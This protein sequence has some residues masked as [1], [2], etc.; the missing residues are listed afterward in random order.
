[1][2]FC[3]NTVTALST[4]EPMLN[5]AEMANGKMIDILRKKLSDVVV[6]TGL[7]NH[8][9]LY[10]LL[11]YNYMKK[12]LFLFAVVLTA[13][14]ILAADVSLKEAKSAA[15][16]F[17][18]KQIKA[19]SLNATAASNLQLVK[20]EASVAKPTA[21]D[22][23]IFNTDHSY[24][25]VSGD[26]QAPEILMYGVEGKLDMD[27][28]PPAMQWL[29]NK[30]KYQI[31]GL[32]AGTMK[33]VS[34]P[35]FS[36]T[37]VAPLVT[38]NWDQ[39]SPYNN[40]CPT[41]G[42]RRAVTGCPAT[43]LA[44]CYYKWKWPETFPALPA[45][46][47]SSS[48]GYSAAALAERAA[49]WDNIIDEYTGPS[50]YSSTTAQKNAVAW[51]MR[52]AGQAIPD[53]M[54]GADASG[55]DDPEIY[56]GVLNMGY[57]DA[58]YLQLTQIY[59]S[60][61]T[62]T[63][64]PQQ[65]TDAQWNQFMLNELYNGRPIEYLA[66][67]ITNGQVSGHA[68]N[69]F[70]CNTSGQYYVNWGWSGDSNG[71]C[72]LHNFTTATGSTGQSGS[73]VF[74]YGEAMI[75]GIEPPAGASN[76]PSLTISPTSLSFTGCT[77]GETYTK[78]FT[79]SGANLTDNV[80]I[81]SDKDAFTVSP[82][83]LTA[84]QAMAGATITVTF[85]PTAAG[86]Q[87]GTITVAS[88]GAT[89]KTVTVSGSATVP[90]PVLTVN[91]TSLSFSGCVVGQ[92]YTQTF[93]VSA[94]N[95]TGSVNISSNNAR[96]TVSPSTLTAAQ[97]MAGATITVTYSPTAAGTH[98]GTISV[99]STGATTKTVS[100]SG[101]AT[102]T[103]TMTVTPSTLNMSTEVG[104]PV[105]AIFHLQGSNLTSTVMLSVSGTGFSINKTNILKSAANN[106]TDVTVTYNPTSAGTHTGT[107][108]LTSNG[109]EPVTVAL[110]GVASMPKFAPVML[111]ADE[112]K[113]TAT[114]FC[115]DWT[116]QTDAQTV[117][118]YTLEVSAMT[119]EQETEANGVM[120]RA[121]E[122]GDALYRLIT[123]ITDKFYTVNE[124]AAEGT[125]LYK[126]KALYL[127]GTE[128]EW[129]NIEEVTLSASYLLGDINRDGHISIKDATDLID[130][131]LGGSS[132]GLDLVA[133]D[134]NSDNNVSIKDATDLIDYLLGGG[135]Q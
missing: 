100:V 63:N 33:P 48:G 26:D 129:S 101:T 117:A 110:N 79:V 119:V 74:K 25:V 89:S 43:S 61:W 6:V 34:A 9:T 128:S 94:T 80:T 127:D 70:G 71:Y 107:V 97:A 130:Y 44:M 3:A 13:Q 4:F 64:G 39:S 56:Q 87:N 29:L 5:K 131:L 69:V 1:M 108:T 86:T 19:G 42:G 123:G 112:S 115:A 134:F 30:Y 77:A 37:A 55:A 113:I 59:Q 53:Y 88:S 10:I 90:T 116:D 73:Y 118:S 135:A 109:A 105:T 78:T 8:C 92:S 36:A 31:D 68:F 2:Q 66:C 75:I 50:N 132:E 95:V 35:M 126:V 15:N 32:K 102:S 84:A 12:I 85:A 40:Q 54:Y 24:V 133:A 125:F 22:Y 124:L 21:V 122:S 17:I 27:N 120:L 93:T 20:A 121:S 60:G 99:T 91:P 11:N 18:T 14:Q 7:S 67:D 52:Y 45:I 57:T 62:Y 82:S 49:D 28:I 65:Y 83:T 76:N 51:L 114:S 23:Y 81:S 47:S 46:S 58:Q 111:P 98:T 104:T 103:P 38:A 41:S 16:A 96:F 72:T 106:G